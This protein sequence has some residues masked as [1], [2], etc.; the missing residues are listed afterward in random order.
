MRFS[1]YI[2]NL[3]VFDILTSIFMFRVSFLGIGGIIS[4]DSCQKCIKSSLDNVSL[5]QS[6]WFKRK[7]YRI[8]EDGNYYYGK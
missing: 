6:A 4:A 5:D 7:A 8:R 1:G 2:F 3:E